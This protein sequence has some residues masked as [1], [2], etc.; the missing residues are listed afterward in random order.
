MDQEAVFPNCALHDAELKNL[1]SKLDRVLV[2]VEGDN[3]HVGLKMEVDRLSRAVSVYTRIFWIVMG[4][5]IA[6]IMQHVFT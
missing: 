2:C 6:A 4:A 1:H 5:L 3:D